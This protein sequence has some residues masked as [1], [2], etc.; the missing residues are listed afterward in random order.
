[1]KEKLYSLD[2]VIF[3]EDTPSNF[4]LDIG[5]E[6]YSGYAV[7]IEARELVRNFSENII[8]D[9]DCVLADLV[10]ESEGQLLIDQEKIDELQNLIEDFMQKNAKVGCRRI[11]DVK[12][13]VYFQNE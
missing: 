8:D 12:K 1:M 9:M 13:H 11:I 5:D 7:D 2:G 3:N 6:Y 4:D 10:S